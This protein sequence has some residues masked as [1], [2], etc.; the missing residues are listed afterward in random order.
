M[1]AIDIL[2]LLSQLNQCAEIPMYVWLDYQSHNTRFCCHRKSISKIHLQKKVEIGFPLGYSGFICVWP[3]SCS[4]FLFLFMTKIR[5]SLRCWLV[6]PPNTMA[7][8]YHHRRSQTVILRLTVIFCV[9]QQ[10]TI[11]IFIIV[12]HRTLWPVSKLIKLI[13][14]IR[15]QVSKSWITV[16]ACVCLTTNQSRGGGHGF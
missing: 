1:R 12:A 11:N 3:F 6:L 7:T 16:T 15:T 2:P 14:M 9:Q 13:T 8:K 4:S 5:I 10:P